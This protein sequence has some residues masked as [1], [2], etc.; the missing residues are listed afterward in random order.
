MFMFITLYPAGNIEW[1]R[2]VNRN[3]MVEMF[4]V[5]KY[6]FTGPSRYGSQ[7]KRN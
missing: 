6:R 5:P 1:I 2:L 7:P 3:A 4:A